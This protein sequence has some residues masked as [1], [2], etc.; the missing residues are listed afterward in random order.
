M[1]LV[2]ECVGVSLDGR[3]VVNPVNTEWIGQ[4]LSFWS[5][6]RL[7][8]VSIIEYSRERY[9]QSPRFPLD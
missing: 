6:L 3:H 9:L 5:K 1:I 7:L 2:P 4:Q 8:P